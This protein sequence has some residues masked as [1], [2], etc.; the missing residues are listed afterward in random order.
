MI[1]TRPRSP[2]ETPLRTVAEWLSDS[3][4]EIR[5]SDSGGVVTGLAISSQRVQPGDLYVAPAGARAHGASFAD[6]AVAAGA[7]AVLTDPAGADLC[8]TTSTGTPVASHR[9]APAGAANDAPC[10]RAP[11]GAT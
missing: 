8:A 10:A 7:V 3:L 1:P 5:A 11:A 2:R 9:S 4:L 6:Q